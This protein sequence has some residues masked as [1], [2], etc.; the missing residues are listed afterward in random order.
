MPVRKYRPTTPGRRFGNVSTFEEITK[1]G[2]EKSLVIP[3]KRTGGRNVYGRVTARRKSGGHKRKIRIIDF[4][5]D[6]HDTPAR[7]IAIEYDPNR[8]GNLALVEYTDKER[9]Y[10]IAPVGLKVG[11]E[12]RAGLKNV[13]I[14][15]GNAMPLTNIPLGTP[16]YNLEITPGRGGQIARSAGNMATIMAKEG[17]SAHVRLPSGE[18]R[19]VRVTCF[20]TIGQVGNVDHDAISLGKAGRSRYLGKAP[21]SRGVVKNPHDHPMGGGE[22]KSSGGRHPCS[23]WGQLAKGLKTRKP[24]KSDK[25]ILKRRK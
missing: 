11:D 23:P 16:I 21:R 24:K 20:A 12:V 7:V 10:I 19:L 25:Y 15:T 9:R 5:R 8:S 17:N 18:V 6:K 14:K 3:R 4:K 1:T 13:E 2:P 22:G